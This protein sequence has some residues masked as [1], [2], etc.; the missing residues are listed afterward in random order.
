M[1]KLHNVAQPSPWELNWLIANILQ[2]TR[3][4][5]IAKSLQ[6]LSK[7]YYSKL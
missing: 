2:L 1:A 6:T 4:V 3:N 7:K 5:S